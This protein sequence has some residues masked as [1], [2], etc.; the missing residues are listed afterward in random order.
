MSTLPPPPPF[1]AGSQYPPPPPSPSPHSQS[2][3]SAVP[4][5]KRGRYLIVAIVAVVVIAIVAFFGLRPHYD[6]ELATVSE[7]VAGEATPL[8][9]KVSNAGSWSGTFEERVFVDGSE[10]QT[11]RF[12]LPGGESASVDVPLPE[13]LSSGDHVV[14]VGDNTLTVH[15]MRPA[16]FEVMDLYSSHSLVKSGATATV[17]AS[18]ANTGDVGGGVQSDCSRRWPQG[19]RT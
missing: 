7:L 12:R 16:A 18:I 13:D 17:T 6:V 2:G 11:V 8:T 5:K 19:G 10:L 15:V 3:V 14:E 4:P 1:G 9:V